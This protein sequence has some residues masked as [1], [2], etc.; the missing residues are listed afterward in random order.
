MNASHLADLGERLRHR[1]RLHARV[2][3]AS[4]TA[5]T[6]SHASAPDAISRIYVINLDRKPDRWK[7][8]QRELNRFQARHGEPLTTITRRFSA[9]DARYLRTTPD[10]GTLITEFSLAD[11]LTVAPNPQL[12]I[13]DQTR[14]LKI[15]MTRQEIAVALSHIEVWRHVAT[16]DATNTLVLEDDVF[17]AYGFAGGLERTWSAL[18]RH[19]QADRGWDLLYLS[20][21]ETN[22]GTRQRIKAALYQPL[23][24]LWQASGYVLSKQG[25]QRLLDLLPMHGPVDLWLN[26]QFEKLTVYTAGRSLIEQRIDEPS[27]NAYSVLP[28]LS[29]VGVV[30]R[31]KPLVAEVRHLQQPVVAFG[32]AGTGLTSL[33]TALSMLGY[34]CLSDLT[35]LPVSEQAALLQSR[36]KQAFNAYV[37]IGG[38]TPA[39]MNEIS[40]R[41]P[42]AR[43]ICTSSNPG[44]VKGLPVDRVL[45]LASHVTEKWAELSGFLGLTYPSFP[46]PAAEELGQRQIDDVSPFERYTVQDL[47]YDK[48]PWILAKSP[49]RSNGIS[50]KRSESS[51][52]EGPS[53]D[54]ISGRTLNPRDWS[55]RG[56]TFPSNLSLFSP[57]N[58]MEAAGSPAR[59]RFQAEATPVRAYTSAAIASCRSYLYGRFS[60]ILRPARGSGLITGLFLHRNGPRQEIDIEFLGKDPT[61][62][63]VNVFF[64][65]GPAG[66]KLEYGYRGTPTVIDLR[67]DAAASFHEYGIE[68][69]PDAIRWRVDGQVVYE[70]AP[71]GPTP[72]PDQ[73]LEFNINL[74]HS[75]SKEFAG[76]LSIE[77]TSAVAELNSIKVETLK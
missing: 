23:P 11:Q 29:Q 34:T 25:A 10:N 48:S 66:T 59:L 45:Q 74:W 47:R 53:A 4:R 5:Q 77:Q 22:P 20:F 31:E 68:W 65:P 62:M 72:I 12:F 75:R 56:D 71:W 61:K 51:F 33:A 37:N 54:W 41:Y 30:T 17:L 70:R 38:L 46:Y 57:K 8:L 63:L 21:H 39:V 15:S 76:R 60:A 6:F 43:F 42:K 14:A 16:G 64:N 44:P 58:F 52:N 7:R 26:L 24:G 55:L 50:V 9:T 2:L 40:S 13:N 69:L 3:D 27:T 35:D 73:P 36:R 32:D 67:F 1:L 28:V 49:E 18:H 19:V